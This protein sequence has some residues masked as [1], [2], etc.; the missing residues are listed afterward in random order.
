MSNTSDESTSSQKTP[1][2]ALTDC[3]LSQYKVC[4]TGVAAGT[5]YTLRNKKGLAP[6]LVAGAGGTVVDMFYGYYQACS[7]EVEAYNDDLEKQMKSGEF[8]DKIAAKAV[9]RAEG[10]TRR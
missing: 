10:S 9:A 4:A 5:I 2:A 8:A 7:K 6:M 3:L 1:G